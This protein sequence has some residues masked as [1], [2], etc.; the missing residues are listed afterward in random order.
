MRLAQGCIVQRGD[1][2]QY[3]VITVNRKWL[4]RWHSGKESAANAGN[5]GSTPGSGI[6]PG[7]GNG[8]P[9]QYSCLENPRGQRSLMG[10]SPRDGKEPDTEHAPML[11]ESNLKNCIKFKNV[12]N[13]FSPYKS[14]FLGS[15]CSVGGS[16]QEE[17]V[18]LH[19]Y[20]WSLEGSAL[21]PLNWPAVRTH[22]SLPVPLGGYRGE[23]ESGKR[24]LGSGHGEK[25]GIALSG[26]RSH[27]PQLCPVL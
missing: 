19:L 9:L 16:P 24:K 26:V 27:I 22:G 20:T 8:N 23:R 12:L 5:A 2:G 4:H 21:C 11:I 17:F 14:V 10:Y 13:L 3:F 7:V 6:S 15:P 1:H 25:T 18:V